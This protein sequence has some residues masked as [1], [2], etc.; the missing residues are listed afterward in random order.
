VPKEVLYR[1]MSSPTPDPRELNPAV[2]SELSKVVMKMMARRPSDR[3]QT[4]AEVAEALKKV[5]FTQPTSTSKKMLPIRPLG[6]KPM[7]RPGGGRPGAP[8][9]GS[10]RLGGKDALR[11]RRPGR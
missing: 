7:L 6:K 8:R 5:N 4:P 3:F 10:G 1:R 9:P 11:R 2:P